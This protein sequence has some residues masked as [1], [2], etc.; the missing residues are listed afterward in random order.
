M[1]ANNGDFQGGKTTLYHVSPRKTRE[2]IEHFG[3][4]ARTPNITG[5]APRGVYLSMKTPNPVYGDDVYTVTRRKGR[6]IRQD[7]DSSEY[8]TPQSVPTSDVKRVGHVITNS[9]GHPEVHWHPEE[10]CNG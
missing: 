3:L 5:H 7:P 8:Y 9:N 10:H 2:Q 4:F 1:G 6:S